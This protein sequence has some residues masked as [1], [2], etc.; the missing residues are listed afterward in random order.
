[1]NGLLAIAGAHKAATA[2]L[3][4]TV[5][6]GGGVIHAATDDAT[7]ATV[8]KVVDGDTI[9]VQYDGETHRVRLLNVNAP[10]SVDPNKPVE[11]MGPEAS[12]FLA[13]RLPVGTDVRL[14]WDQEKS[15]KYGRELAAV[16][17][18]DEF[19]DAEIARAGYGVAMSVGANTKYL[20]PVQTAQR[21]AEIAGR[22]LHSGSL[23]CTVPAQVSA[24][25]DAA[26]T[27]VS[28]A[29]TSSAPLSEYDTHAGDVAAVIVT[30][31]ALSGVLSGPTDVFPMAAHSAGATAILRGRVTAALS[32]LAQAQSAN[33]SARAAEQQRLD[34]AAAKAARE[35]AEKAARE[36][37]E[38][39]AR[40]AAAEAAQRQ[41]DEAAA[42]AARHA[43]DQAASRQTATP[44]RPSSSAPRTAA[45]TSSNDDSR[46]GSSGGASGYTGCRSY[47]PGG[48][49]WTP[50]DC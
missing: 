4:A 43:A 38:E 16:F 23:E 28:Q 5:I 25:E 40:R 44:A 12:E 39:A 31:K 20:S 26:A 33:S 48:K 18:G 9:D 42:E 29:P 2:V 35:A 14:E 37:A 49:T 1:M 45:P 30:A 27:V 7:T 32:R 19:I 50:I 13:G 15:D 6:V 47:A 11:C 24:V 21:E 41:A 17:L 36:A 3:A 46:S 8:T 22:G 34:A 10:E